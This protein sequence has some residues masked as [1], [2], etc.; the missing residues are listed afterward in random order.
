MGARPV[1]PRSLSLFAQN[2]LKSSKLMSEAEQ[3]IA[4]FD[5]AR[6]GHLWS[7]AVRLQREVMELREQSEYERERGREVWAV[8]LDLQKQ[9][10]ELR[11]VNAELLEAL[12]YTRLFVA[13]P[14]PVSDKID[15]IIAKAEGRNEGPMHRFRKMLDEAEEKG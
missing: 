14:T 6:A 12:K 5:R 15:G 9:V 8:A 1:P 7:A 13:Q 3:H 2:F 4:A 11:E 10:L